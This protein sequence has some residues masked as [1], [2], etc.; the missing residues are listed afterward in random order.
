MT[1]ARH[2]LIT[3]VL[4]LLASAPA[5]AQQPARGG[6]LVALYPGTPAGGTGVLERLQARPQL[7]VG[8]LGATQGPYSVR[9]TLLDLSQGHRLSRSG[10]EPHELPGLRL[11]GT[12]IRGW[13][14]AVRR[15]GTA[16]ADI[17]PGLLAASVPGGA[18]YVGLDGASNVEAIVAAD[19]NG[20]VAEVDLG[21][22]RDVAERAR[23]MLERRPLVV[24]ALPTGAA[25]ER[26][27]DHLIGAH[28]PTELL[29]VIRTPPRAR[30]A[31]QLPIGTL[32]L[33]DP[34]RPGLLRSPTTRHDGLVA[35]HDVLPTV[36]EHLALPVPDPV[37]GR[38]MFVTYDRDDASYLR[39]FERR[40]RVVGP[41]R[42]PTLLA[43]VGAMVLVALAGLAL[44]RL[45]PAWRLIGLALLYVPSV[46]LI[47]AALAPSYRV[48][49]LLTALGPLALAA[50]TDRLV[51]WPRAPAVPALGGVAA[52]VVD[53]AFGSPLIVRSLLG[54]NP[55]FGARWYGIGNELEAALPVMLLVGIAAAVGA[56]TRSYRL[57]ALFGGGMLVLGALVGAGRLGAD[58][59]GVITIGAGG[60]VAVLLSLPGRLTRRR[61]LLACAAPVAAVLLLAVLDLITGGDSHFTATVL[62]ADDTGALAD[63]VDRRM[64]LARNALLRGLMP[65]FTLLSIAL[66]VLAWRR[67]A[68]LYAPVEDRPAWAAAV[69]GGAVGGIVGSLANDSGP[70]LLVIGVI[71]LL[72]ATS[73]LRGGP[74]SAGVPRT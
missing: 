34:D 54:P 11:E 1:L 4:L 20:E 21:G 57:A 9:Q 18:G 47:V 41:R 5:V 6:A 46:A 68:T 72:G 14:A 27:L 66:V 42:N 7:S 35:G 60:A 15:A 38:A 30:D 36:L 53:L 59:G 40:L 62:G 12:S 25:G 73:Y 31:Q 13:V 23:A 19:Q 50:V 43:I 58:V 44:R 29:M 26:A 71:L 37:R 24:A 61:I 49:L 39:D 56:A 32:G 33:G 65:L 22:P 48:E 10:Y 63:V 55:R 16:P 8:L 3:I 64:T 74:P 45:R 52:Y 28:R 69:A 17:R 70:I 67:R 2:A 51:P